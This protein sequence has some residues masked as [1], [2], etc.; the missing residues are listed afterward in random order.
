MERR[1][2]AGAVRLRE[3]VDRGQLARRLGVTRQAVSAWLV[4]DAVPSP[5]RM[6][7]LEREYGIPMRAW[8]EEPDATGMG[9]P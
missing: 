8:T 5:A 2:S 7:A 9:E 4:G 3:L 1:L 6:A